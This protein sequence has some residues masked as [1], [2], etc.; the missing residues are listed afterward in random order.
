MTEGSMAPVERPGPRRQ[1]GEQEHLEEDGG[2]TQE[3]LVAGQEPSEHLR[4]DTG[5]PERE[6]RKDDKSLIDRAKDRLKGS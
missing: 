3:G 2:V 1:E 6:E 5:Q 4:E